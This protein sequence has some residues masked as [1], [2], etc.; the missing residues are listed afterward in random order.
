MQRNRNL[1]GPVLVLGEKRAAERETPPR[2]DKI[3]HI[4]RGICVS[5]EEKILQKECDDLRFNYIL[6]D[7]S[8]AYEKII[9]AL[10]GT[11]VGRSAENS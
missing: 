1:V 3:N 4:C 6:T 7:G 5:R 9:T 2:T 11:A 10:Y 8:K